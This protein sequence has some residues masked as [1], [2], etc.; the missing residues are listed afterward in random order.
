MILIFIAIET[1]ALI[2]SSE[3]IGLYNIYNEVE[4]LSNKSSIIIT[5]YSISP[6]TSLVNK[7]NI[8]NRLS[9][10]SGVK[11]IEFIVL[12]LGNVED[13]NVVFLGINNYNNYC[14]YPSISA[15]K[16]LNLKVNQTFIVY[17]AFS[18]T[19]IELI[20]C[21]FSNTI[22]FGIE[23]SNNIAYQIHGGGINENLA[24]IAII[25]L[26]NTS[27]KENVIK[28]LQLPSFESSLIKKVSVVVESLNNE[29]I[30][31]EYSKASTIYYNKLGIPRIAFISLAIA[32]IIIISIGS[33]INGE[34]MALTEN[35]TFNIFHYYGL[36][37]NRL[38]LI[39]ILV[40]LI[41]FMFSIPF[42]ILIF[43]FFSQ[44]M[45]TDVFGFDLIPR[46]NYEIIFIAF[47]VILTISSISTFINT[48][49]SL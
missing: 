17:P 12:S 30:Q 38:S 8:L 31:Q 46:T 13:K 26:L 42:S 21:N 44:N 35:E 7:E 1:S 10:V 25:N 43:Y 28:A 9:N 16:E 11:N 6:F 45:R 3:V 20:V 47:L 36:S 37:K 18:N 5:G 23:V 15:E 32:A 27:Y 34:V 49:G 2:I 22:P 33:Y 24:S 4:S 41:S 14:A 29:K 48:R 19:P 40:N 39:S